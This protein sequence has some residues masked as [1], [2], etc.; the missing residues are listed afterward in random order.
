L[1]AADGGSNESRD[2]YDVVVG[3]EKRHR[4]TTDEEDSGEFEAINILQAAYCKK[5]AKAASLIV[6][7]L[8]DKAFKTFQSVSKDP[9][10]MWNNLEA[11]YAGNSM[12]KKLN[13]FTEAHYKKVGKGQTMSDHVGDLETIFAK[14]ENAG[15]EVAVIGCS[16]CK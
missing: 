14:L 4:N 2:L 13:L 6:N 10:E 7:T 1:E 12:N 11:R 9:I 5:M 3:I 16:Y 15:H 8:R